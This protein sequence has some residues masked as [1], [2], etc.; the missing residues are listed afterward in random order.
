MNRL[1]H[2]HNFAAAAHAGQKR[3]FTNE[4]YLNH[5]EATAQFLWE[6]TN[7]DASV[8]DLIAAI[9]HDIVED[10][11]ITLDDVGKEFGKVIMDLVSELTTDPAIKAIEGKKKYL[12]KKLNS[13]SSRALSIKLSD[14]LSNIISLTDEVTPIDFIKWYVKETSYLVDNLNRELNGEQEYLIHNIK[15]V[16]LFLRINKDF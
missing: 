2:A 12:S 15:R 3:K 8:D 10:T 7:G 4:P 13:M 9:L 6:A 1:I 16:L 5:L 14:R 11:D